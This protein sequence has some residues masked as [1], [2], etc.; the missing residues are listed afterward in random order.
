MQHTCSY[1]IG[2]GS[3][4]IPPQDINSSDAP[5]AVEGVYELKLPGLPVRMVSPWAM[6]GRLSRKVLSRLPQQPWAMLAALRTLHCRILSSTPHPD[7][8]RLTI[9]EDNV[10][11]FEEVTELESRIKGMQGRLKMLETKPRARCAR[12]R[13]GG[14]RRLSRGSMIK[15]NLR[16]VVAVGSSHLKMHASK[17]S[18]S[19]HTLRRGNV[20]IQV[21]SNGTIPLQ[22]HASES[23]L[24]PAD[25]SSASALQVSSRDPAYPRSLSPA[26]LYLSL[27]SPDAGAGAVLM[28]VTGDRGFAASPSAA[29][30]RAT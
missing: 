21:S 3:I 24:C 16:C 14:A 22:T 7:L 28:Q 9:R 10:P 13:N 26:P 8:R 25:T 29:A 23:P 12:A 4:T 15:E 18:H 2:G 17:R 19:K 20:P 30:L 5:G 27:C 6:A 11:L 1:Y